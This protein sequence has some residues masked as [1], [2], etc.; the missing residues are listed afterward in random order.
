MTIQANSNTEIDPRKIMI[1]LDMF[2]D[3][4]NVDSAQEKNL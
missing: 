4:I 3:A 1:E 2:V